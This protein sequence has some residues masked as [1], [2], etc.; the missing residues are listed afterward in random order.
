MK[1]AVIIG[2]TRQGR[3]TPQQAKWVFNTAKQLD[4]VDAELVDLKDY[5]MP[6]FDEAI[7]PRYNPERKIDP[8]VAPWLKKLEE[9]DAYVFVTPEYNHSIPGVLKNALD[10]VTW[11]FLHKPTTVVSHGANGGARAM[12]DL[13]EILSESR[14]VVV[15]AASSVA[16]SGMSEVIDEAGNLSEAV[17]ANPYGPQGGLDAL[18][19]DLKW[20][21]DVLSAARARE[22]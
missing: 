19:T 5:P 14:A 4:G 11:E 10:Y 12:T 16:V 8:A 1:L 9:F 13:K 15:P 18:L 20:Y 2:A 21:S 6:F 3:K 7:S 17:K 22:A